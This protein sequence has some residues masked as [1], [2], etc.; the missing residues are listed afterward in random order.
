MDLV[1]VLEEIGTG[2]GT[3]T[4]DF[5]YSGVDRALSLLIDGITP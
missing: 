4:G 3:V 2:T 1:F 5:V